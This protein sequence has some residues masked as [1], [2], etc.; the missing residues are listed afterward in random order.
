MAKKKYDY[1]QPEDM[2][3]V[4]SEFKKGKKGMNLSYGMITPN[5]FLRDT[6][7]AVYT[8]VY[9]TLQRNQSMAKTLIHPKKV[10]NSFNTF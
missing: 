3:R 10:K 9:V 1:V 5:A 2:Q 6:Y 4:L 8:V 7:K